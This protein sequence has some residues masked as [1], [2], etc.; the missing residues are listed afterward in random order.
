MK[1]ILRDWL[2]TVGV[3]NTSLSTFRIYNYTQSLYILYS[4]YNFVVKST[5][6][7][8]FV[9]KRTVQ[10]QLGRTPVTWLNDCTWTKNFKPS[11]LKRLTLK[12]RWNDEG[13][14]T[15]K[16]TI[17]SW[18][19]VWETDVSCQWVT[20]DKSETLTI[21]GVCQNTVCSTWGVVQRKTRPLHLQS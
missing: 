9:V 7:T 3:T 17:L 15:L 14:G 2:L 5:V 4:K 12:W 18:G 1:K 19:S 16:G 21:W 13:G 11:P 10:P 20:R 8:Y 6:R